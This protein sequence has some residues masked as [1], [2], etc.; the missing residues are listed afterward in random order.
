MT[1]ANGQ[2][3]I[4]DAS[5]SGSVTLGLSA[6]PRRVFPFVQKPAG[7]LNLFASIVD[8]TLSATGFTFNLSGLTDSANY[9]LDYILIF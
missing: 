2:C 6:T 3:A 7:G 5:D 1:T 8:G 4:G 9:K